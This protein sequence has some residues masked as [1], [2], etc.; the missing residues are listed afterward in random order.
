M[1]SKSAHLDWNSTSSFLLL[2]LVVMPNALVTGYRTQ[3]LEVVP[4]THGA[5]LACTGNAS[6]RPGSPGPED[7]EAHTTQQRIKPGTLKSVPQEAENIHWA[8][9]F[10]ECLEVVG[11]S[12][13]LDLNNV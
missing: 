8:L 7:G 3:V 9:L 11:I 1:I 13:P 4:P 12:V 2:L 6:I 5:F 10:Q